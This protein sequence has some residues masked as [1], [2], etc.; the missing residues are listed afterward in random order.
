MGLFSTAKLFGMTI[1]ES[2]DDG[3]DFTNPDADYRR[4]FLGEDGLLHVK[5]SAGAV[6][7]P[8]STGSGGY[9]EGSGSFPG[10]PT[11]GDKYYRTD[12]DR[13]YVYDGTRWVTVAEFILPIQV[14]DV[15]Q[16][17]TTTRT[18]ATAALDLANAGI[19]ITT[20]V[21]A[22]FT[23]GGSGSAGFTYQLARRAADTTDTSIGSSFST[24]TAPDT[25]SNWVT[26]DTAI[27]VAVTT[28]KILVL[29]VTKVSTP[30]ST[31]CNAAV[32]YRLIG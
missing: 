25:N 19:Y 8:Y 15:L 6:T 10:G 30:T 24:H 20:L 28:D 29:G 2:A 12:R 27:G 26:H 9:S 31:Y 21:I 5:D 16:P 3:S 32:R 4:L 1:R 13:L 23:I 11:T 14:V 22:T 17:A 18:I 7:N